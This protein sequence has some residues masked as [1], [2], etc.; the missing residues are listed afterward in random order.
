MHI[1]VCKQLEQSNQSYMWCCGVILCFYFLFFPASIKLF[2]KYLKIATLN[3]K[4]YHLSYL[5][6]C[7]TRKGQVKDIR[8]HSDSLLIQYKHAHTH[9][10][11]AFIL[12]ELNTPYD[13]CVCVLFFQL[14]L[15]SAN[16]VFEELTDIERQFHK[17]LY[18]VRAYLNCDRYSVG[19]LDMTKEKV[20]SR[21]STTFCTVITINLHIF[22]LLPGVLWHLA[23]ADGRAAS[24]RWTCNSGWQGDI[25]NTCSTLV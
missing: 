16:K 14:L 24:L 21:W 1:F 12:L 5:H 4:I 2:L 15:W 3:L 18:T 10:T 13:D 11:T 17:A 20:Q 9:T 23:S 8:S 7:E 19:L 6:N 22:C 25:P